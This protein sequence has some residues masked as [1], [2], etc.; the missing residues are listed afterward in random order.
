MAEALEAE[1]VLQDRPCGAALIGVARDHAGDDDG[2][3]VD[4]SC[5][6]EMPAS[7][8]KRPRTRS[9]SKRSSASRRAAAQCPS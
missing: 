3:G 4:L 8:R 2:Q 5:H 1:D 6:A 7:S 9:W